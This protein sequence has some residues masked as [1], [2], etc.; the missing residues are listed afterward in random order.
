M[1]FAFEFEITGAPIA[2][3]EAS[4]N[5]SAPANTRIFQAPKSTD[6]PGGILGCSIAL[7]Q[8]DGTS[9][10]CTVWVKDTK[11]NK[12]FQFGPAAFTVTALAMSEPI[13]VPQA[14]EVFVQVV[15]A[16]GNPTKILAHFMQ[17]PATSFA[18]GGGTSGGTVSA[19]QGTAAAVAGAWPVKITDGTDTALVDASGDLLV[20][21][22]FAPAAED[23]TNAVIAVVRRPVAVSTYCATL[24]TYYAAAVTKANIKVSAGTVA[25][26]LF[27]NNNAAKRFLQLH[28]KA[29]APAAAEAPL[30]SIPVPANS[31]VM[32]DGTLLGPNGT[33]FSTGIGWA[34]STTLATFTDSATASEHSISLWY[35]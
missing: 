11:R 13:A 20:A 26:V 14:A 34:V 19:T 30:L 5:V 24:F 10:T 27:E 23:N 29:S 15:T 32:V 28:N 4:P 16:T 33:A 31:V 21:E 35:K 25:S 7:T 17:V 12:F 1:S 2:G 8:Y 6:D 18:Q 3:S 9:S 22:A